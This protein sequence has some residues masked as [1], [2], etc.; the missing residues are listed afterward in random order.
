LENT[1]EMTIS[2]DMV[3]KGGEKTL[4][5]MRGTWEDGFRRLFSWK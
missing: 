5:E 2:Y 1:F 3:W 4:V